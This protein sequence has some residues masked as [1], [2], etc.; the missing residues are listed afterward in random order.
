[1]F[2]IYTFLKKK[3][4]IKNCDLQIFAAGERGKYSELN[5]FVDFVT[6]INV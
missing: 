6:Q 3:I 4:I 5:T 2:K 1:M